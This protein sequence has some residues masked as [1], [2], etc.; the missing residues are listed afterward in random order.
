MNDAVQR[1]ASRLILL[2]AERRVLLLLH[3]GV[4]GKTFWAPPGGGL[5]AGETFEDA[6]VREAWEE[7]GLARPHLIRLWERTTDFLYTEHPLRQQECFFLVEGALPNLSPETRKA[8]IEE[9][10]LELRWWTTDEI[11]AASEPIFPE[12]LTSELSKIPT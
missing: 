1:R 2:D 12:G 4:N 3:A 9:G 11:D 8:H 7:L 10:I 5:E 6:A